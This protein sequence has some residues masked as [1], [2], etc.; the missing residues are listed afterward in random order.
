MPRR[1]NLL[2]TGREDVLQ[3]LK[4]QLIPG[5]SEKQP[6]SIFQGIGGSGKSEMAIRF[7]EENKHR[8]RCLDPH[9]RIL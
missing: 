7:A 1:S 2:F 6:M 3:R 4:T 8:Y 5:S 9:L